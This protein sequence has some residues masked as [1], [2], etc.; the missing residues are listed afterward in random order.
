ML[1]HRPCLPA[2]CPLVAGGPTRGCMCTT[3]TNRSSRQM[4]TTWQV[5]MPQVIMCRPVRPA[6]QPARLSVGS[7]CVEVAFQVWRGSHMTVVGGAAQAPPAKLPS[8]PPLQP[9]HAKRAMS[10]FPLCRGR[11]YGVDYRFDRGSVKVCSASHMPSWAPAVLLIV[12]LVPNGNR[13]GRAPSAPASPVPPSPTRGKS[14]TPH[15]P[16][17]HRCSPGTDLSWYK[18]IPVPTSYM[19][20][21]S[22]ILKQSRLVCLCLMPLYLVAVKCTQRSR[23]PHLSPT[24]WHPYP[25]QST[26]S[27]AAT[28][29]ASRRGWCTWPTTTSPR[30]RLFGW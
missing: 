22:G 10:E 18:N 9:D 4:C 25:A 30:V 21:N 13:V 17:P 7:C 11:Y 14:S 24:S 19:A 28:T 8:P 20:C 26:T 29:T 5:G 27:S 12:L 15:S 6:R 3:S 2:S 1:P 23:A 16:L